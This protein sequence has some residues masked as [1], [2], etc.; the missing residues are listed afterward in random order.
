MLVAAA[1]VAVVAVGAA[2]VVA[3]V[4]AQLVARLMVARLMVV[5]VVVVVVV[6]KG[7]G[8]TNTKARKYEDKGSTC[9]YT[10]LDKGLRCSGGIIFNSQWC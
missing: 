4:M 9:G 10:R 3:V 1:V 2:A 8:S 7:E 6:A 5:V